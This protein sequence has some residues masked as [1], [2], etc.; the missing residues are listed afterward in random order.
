MEFETIITRVENGVGVVQFNRPKALNALNATLLRE[1]ATALTA[2]DNDDAIGC[3]LLT[4]S[5]K[6][7]AAGADIK[8][9]MTATPAEMMG[10]SVYQDLRQIF[11][12]R[13][14]L[15]GVVSGYALGGGFEL[16]MG[17]DI[18]V[19]SETAQF[20][21]P[22]ITLGV[23]PGWG[24]TQRL[25]YAVGKSVAMEMVLNGRY[26][27]PD[28]AVHFGLVS[29]VY[30]KESYMGDASALASKIASRAP[31]AKEIGKEAINKAYELSLS[32]GLA[33]EQ[34]V[35]Q[36]LFSTADQKEG[37]EAF[38]KKRQAVWKGK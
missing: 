23:I 8:D 3:L 26:L 36:M 33:Y 16:A 37:M 22:E 25:T 13:K 9:M 34:R 35:F 38:V 30:P 10:W 2:F 31:I 4:G 6:A 27:N 7:F 1:T 19:C 17:C 21:L 24:G 29:H 15:V 12:L 20:G 28:E 32:E 18:M 11:N 5:D 14:P